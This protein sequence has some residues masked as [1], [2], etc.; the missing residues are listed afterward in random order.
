MAAPHIKLRCFL[1]ASASDE[2]HDVTSVCRERGLTVLFSTEQPAPSLDAFRNLIAIIESA[3]LVIVVLPR[4]SSQSASF[5]ANVFLE[6]GMAV[7]L[8]KT[9]IVVRRSDKQDIPSD[10]ASTQIVTL[11]DSDSRGLGFTLDQ[12]IARSKSTVPHQVERESV[13]SREAVVPFEAGQ[14]DLE[15]ASDELTVKRE[16]ANL[17]T[18]MMQRQVARDASQYL[19][20]S[21]DN[22]SESELQSI[23]LNALKAS[24]AQIT[25]SAESRDDGVDIVVWDERLSRWVGNPLLIEIKKRLPSHSI[26][27]QQ[28]QKLLER[29]GLSAGVLLLL[30]MDGK[31]SA[32]STYP[33]LSLSVD[34]FLRELST[35]ALWRIVRD[36]RNSAVH[37]R[38]PAR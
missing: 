31:P 20:E 10:L 16:P 22:I 33:V 4:H 7:G 15:V 19:T 18:S 13:Y 11:N 36:L 14:I 26:S 21:R 27:S 6:A 9:L 29:R 37:G 28:A 23:V 32:E 35:R 2:I 3:D 5:S 24:G 1:I 34:D 17:G 12:F 38:V 30:Y 25:A 8:G